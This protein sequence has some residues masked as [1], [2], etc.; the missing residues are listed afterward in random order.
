MWNIIGGPG[1]W[2]AVRQAYNAVWIEFDLKGAPVMPISTSQITEQ[3]HEMTSD[4][5]E[6]ML[7][8]EAV[9][10]RDWECPE[11]DAAWANL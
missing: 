3:L 4:M 7:A 6:L 5:A 10:K 1:R 9:L 8:S 2:K 11:E